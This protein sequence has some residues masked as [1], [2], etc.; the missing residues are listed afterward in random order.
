[1]KKQ[2][3]ILGHPNLDSFCASLAQAY[4]NGVNEVEREIQTLYLADLSFDPVLHHS[5]ALDQPLEPDLLKAQNMIQWADHL[6]L[7]YPTWWGAAPSLMDGFFQRVFTPGFAFQY[8]KGKLF[9]DKCL[10]GRTAH[11]ITTMSTPPWYYRLVYNDCGIQVL[12]KTILGFSGIKTTQITR[13]GPIHKF[14][15]QQRTQW[16]ERVQDMGRAPIPV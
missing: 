10:A 8:Q 7:I 1:M 4:D 5:K 15:D 3:L 13:I 14:T 9:W 6:I 16:I 11:I 2:L 12:K